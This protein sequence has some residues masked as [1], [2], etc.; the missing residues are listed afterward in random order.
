VSAIDTLERQLRDSA[1]RRPRRRRGLWL[2]PAIAAAAVAAL[3]LLRA[4]APN[5]ERPATPPAPTW[6]PVLGDA[7]RG[8]ATISREPVPPE[9]LRAFA[10]LRRAPTAADRS[11]AVR[12]LLRYLGRETHGVRVD[13]IRLLSRRG[14]RLVILVPMDQLDRPVM[15]DPLCV[16]ETVV[17][18]GNPPPGTPPAGSPG[19]AGET[20][21]TLPDLR[22]HGYLGWPGPP[23]GLVPDGVATVKL[24]VRGGRTITAPV[25]GNVY[26]VPDAGFAIQPPR[27]F[28]VNGRE[29]PKR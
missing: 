28:D 4:P 14:D 22:R 5:D 20:C 3:L 12:A 15:R 18:R 16:M 1:R 2:V 7:R 25:R 10:V 9:Q 11:P 24:R 26:D 23:F 27:W 29:I 8:H 21:R 13:A 17:I 6:T 19:G